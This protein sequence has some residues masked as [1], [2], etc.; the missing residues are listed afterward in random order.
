MEQSHFCKLSELEIRYAISD[1]VEKEK[2]FC[3]ANHPGN[4]R[5]PVISFHYEK[6]DINIGSNPIL[7]AKCKLEV[8]DG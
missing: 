2:K 8:S 4:M 6:N 3:V 7:L 5:S 1:W